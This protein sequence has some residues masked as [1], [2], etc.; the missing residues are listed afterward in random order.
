MGRHSLLTARMGQVSERIPRVGDNQENLE[1]NCQA[2]D[3]NRTGT[4]MSAGIVLHQMHN[5]N[6]LN[7]IGRRT[8]PTNAAS[9][10]NAQKSQGFLALSR[11]FKSSGDDRNTPRDSNVH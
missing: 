2:Q 10:R 4:K 5:V 3:L 1:M 9:N 6:D 7:Q 8:T 11:L